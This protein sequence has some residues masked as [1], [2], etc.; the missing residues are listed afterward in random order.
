[1]LEPLRDQFRD[2]LI[3]VLQQAQR[4]SNIIP[5]PLGITP[6]QPRG[7]LLSKL[8]RMLVLL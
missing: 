4:K 6:R 3:L 8:L 2:I 7:Q 1:M 5:L